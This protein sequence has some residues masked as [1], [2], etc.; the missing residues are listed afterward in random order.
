MTDK[1]Y[2][3]SEVLLF[4]YMGIYVCKCLI[5]APTCPKY[6]PI[7]V[8]KCIQPRQ[9]HKNS[10]LAGVVVLKMCADNYLYASCITTT[11]HKLLYSH[12]A[13][14]TML[15]LFL[16]FLY[17]CMVYSLLYYTISQFLKSCLV[18]ISDCCCVHYYHLSSL[19]S[20]HQFPSP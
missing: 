8:N 5:F 4:I 18:N 1:F 7:V 15:L 16:L 2:A 20:S 19:C 17:F 10:T 12:G 9:M 6:I 3:L 11:L 14:F 13:S